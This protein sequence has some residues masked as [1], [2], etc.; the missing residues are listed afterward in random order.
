MKFTVIAFATAAL[1]ITVATAWG[2]ID[3]GKGGK[4]PEIAAGTGSLVTL[5]TVVTCTSEGR[6]NT[7]EGSM[8]ALIGDDRIVLGL[9]DEATAGIEIPISTTSGG[10]NM[11]RTAIP[12][13]E[14]FGDIEMKSLRGETDCGMLMLE[15]SF[16]ALDVECEVKGMGTMK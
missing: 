2:T 5:N 16:R 9:D 8:L 1:A 13:G 12:T 4:M 6:S 7:E 15:Y 3:P 10:F 11:T 14:P